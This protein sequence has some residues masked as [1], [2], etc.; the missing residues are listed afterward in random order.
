MRS[1]GFSPASLFAGGSIGDAFIPEREFT[2]TKSGG[3]VYERVTTTGD[4]VARLTG[5][6]NGINFDQDTFA[7]RPTYT[8]GGGL[9]WLAFDGVGDAMATGAIDFTGTDKVSVF[10]GVRKL[11]DSSFGILYELS[12]NTNSSN[13]SLWASPGYSGRG[14]DSGAFWSASGKGTALQNATTSET[15]SAPQTV[16]QTHLVDI[17]GDTITLRIN[18]TQEAQTSDDLG[19]GNF[20][21]YPL[22]IGAR[23]QSSLYFKGNLYGLIIPGKAALA[24]EIASTEAYMAAKSGVTL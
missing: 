24:D 3:G 17:S 5:M 10:S 16:V 14:S 6:V 22:F 23:N 4:E 20:G 7:K 12:S 8:E 13:G 2:Y 18:G 1:G 21:S 15:F 19:T 9:S 11:D